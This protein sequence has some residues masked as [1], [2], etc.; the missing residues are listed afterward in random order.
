MG[1]NGCWE[2]TGARYPEGYGQ[3]RKILGETRAHRLAYR[4]AFG[5]FN[6][7]EQVLHHCDNPPCCRPDHLFLGSNIDNVADKVS[8]GRHQQ[9]GR[10][11]NAKLTEA[12][13]AE[14]RRLYS[15][16]GANGVSNRKL[17]ERY[18]V[19]RVQ[20]SNITLGRQWRFMR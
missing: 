17:A 13:V 16:R 14:I 12:D 2:W 15:P 11:W 8:K 9:H 5:P 4:L 1:N 19:S 6:H 18:G 3:F 20:I 10:H 7:G